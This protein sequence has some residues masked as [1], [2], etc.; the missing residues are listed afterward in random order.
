MGRQIK[1]N[2]DGTIERHKACLVAKGYTQEE[3]LDYHE[4]F[5]PIAK[6]VTVKTLLA[7][8]A[9]KGLIGCKS[10]LIPMD[11]NLKFSK[12]E[13]K[14]LQDPSEFRRFIGRLLY[15]SITR[16]DLSFSVNLL[17]QYNCSPRVPHLQAAHKI[18]RYVKKSPG[19][20]LFFSS[21]SICQLTS[22]FD[23]DWA[24]C[25]DTRRSTTCYCVFLGKSLISWKCK[26][27]TTISRSSSEAEYRSMAAASCELV[28]LRYLLAD[29]T[30]SHT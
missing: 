17:S 25:P 12:D 20:G 27:Q 15:L 22:Y 29:L 24:S 14:L 16:P 21:S 8:A 3:G 13:G 9:V 28:W 18:L 26:K 11:P 5:S 6:L 30:I 19:Q 2:S 4:S 1:Y 10:S 23:S 7:V